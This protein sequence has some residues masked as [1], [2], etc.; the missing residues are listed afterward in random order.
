M[1]VF[2]MYLPLRPEG[3]FGTARQVRPFE[4]AAAQLPYM[5][6]CIRDP[7]RAQPARLDRARGQEA[8]PV[9]VRRAIRAAVAPQPPCAQVR[10]RQLGHVVASGVW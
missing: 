10:A 7:I 9:R 6:K 3:A 8:L 2:A 1:A 5:W 4:G